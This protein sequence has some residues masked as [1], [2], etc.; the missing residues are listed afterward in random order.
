MRTE[1]ASAEF[2]KSPWGKHPV[3]QILT[4]EDLLK[5]KTIDY[6]SIPGVNITFKK[7]PKAKNEEAEHPELDYPEE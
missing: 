2:Y 1:A 7:A 5:E 6:P 4:I 3:M